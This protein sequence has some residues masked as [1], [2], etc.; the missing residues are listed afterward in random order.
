MILIISLIFFFGFILCEIKILYE[1]DEILVQKTV[2]FL[3]IKCLFCYLK[4]YRVC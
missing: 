1:K 3:I 2:F 4:K